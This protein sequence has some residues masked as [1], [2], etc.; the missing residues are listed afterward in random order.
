MTRR[1]RLERKIERREDWAASRKKKS[2]A[3]LDSVRRL[4]DSI[5]LGQPILVGHHS[6]KRARKDAERIRSGM[7]K[8]MEHLKMAQHHE[9]AAA[10]LQH[11]LD[12]SIYSDDPDALE[13]IQARIEELEAERT[14]MREENKA[15]RKGNAAHAAFL[16]ITEEQAAKRRELIEQR[17][18][19]E[20]QPHPTYS[21]SNLGGNISRLKERIKH[22]TAQQERA[23]RADAAA[24]GVLIE[25]GEWVRVTFSEKPD[26]NIINALKTAGFRWGGGS[27]SG[28][29]AK[30]PPAVPPRPWS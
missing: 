3:T 19:W 25:G 9:S 7:D 16:G 6:E 4:A 29:R 18:T 28:P 21:L 15:Y 1:E 17:H 5:P 11:Q 20:R 2:D 8:G 13:A 14:Q 22:I 26:R 30:L 24:G 23:A 12:T 27:W 10:G